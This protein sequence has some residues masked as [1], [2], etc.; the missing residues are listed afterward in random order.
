MRSARAQ[1]KT[2]YENRLLYEY[3]DDV[4]H[5]VATLKTCSVNIG[6]PAAL[7]ATRLPSV[8]GYIATRRLFSTRAPSLPTLEA[9]E[10]FHL[11][12]V[13]KNAELQARRLP[14]LI[15]TL[16]EKDNTSEYQKSYIADLQSSLE[17]LN[18]RSV[19]LP[20]DRC[21]TR[22]GIL[23]YRTYCEAHIFQVYSLLITSLC[24]S[25]HISST[26]GMSHWP[27]LSPILLL[28]QLSHSCWS[29]LS[30]SW[31]TAIV[32]YGIALTTLQRAERLAELVCESNSD[33]LVHELQN[34]G[35][36]NWSPYEHP[37]WL[38][39]EVESGIMIRHIQ[40]DIAKR[41][42]EPDCS[43][44][45][46][47]QL[48]MGE[49]KSSVI[50]PMVAAAL[51]DGSRLVRVIIAKPQSKQMAQMLIAKLG[52]L[53][54]HRIY[55]L[56][57]SRD[58][59]LDE[60]AVNVV[61]GMLRECMANR[62]ILLVQPEHIF[63][64]KLMGPECYIS[65]NEKIG[66]K[67]VQIEDFFDERSRDIVDESDENFSVRFELIYTMGVQNPIE[68]SPDRWYFAQQVFDILRR[69][70]P[71]IA[72]QSPGSLEIH[73]AH[74]GGLPRIR[75]L[76]TD[77]GV[78]L[79]NRI[80]KEICEGG[81][82]KLQIARQPA[83]VRRAVYVYIT[84]FELDTEEI[85]A[86][87]GEGFWTDA[88]KGPL[89]LLRGIL[90]GGVLVFTLSQKRWRVNYGLASRTP[91][92][93]LAVPYRAKDS[94]SLRSEFSHPDVVILLTSLCYYYQGLDDE[95]LFTAF[96]HLV[97]S[98]QADIE[99]QSWVHDALDL[100]TAFRQL[101]GVNL[102]DRAQ[103]A[104]DIFPAL[105]HGKSTVDYFLSHVVF[106]KE[107]RDFTHK[108]SA[109]GWDIGKQKTQLVTGFSGT[110]DSKY[111]LPL[112]VGQ[113]DL[114]GQKHTNA[115]VLENILQDGN[116]VE[117]L[118]NF[119]TE[120]AEVTSL[121]ASITQLKPEVQVILDVGAQILELSNVEVAASWLRLS[122]SSKEAVVF[123]N[124]KDEI[125]VMDREG[126]IDL[127]Y[128]SSYASRLDSCL[129]F[130]DESH[131]RG[132]DLKLPVH[133]RAAVTLGAG[134]TKDRLIQACMRMRRLGSGQTVVFCVPP[135]IQAKI[136]STGHVCEPILVSD[137]LLWS[138]GETHR[139]MQRS[140]PIWAVQGQRFTHQQILWQQIMKDGRTILN[141]GHAER[142]LE[143]ESQTLEQRYRPE[144]SS[145]SS[146]LLNLE[147]EDTSSKLIVD[148]C[149][150]FGH[151]Q[152]SSSVLHEEQERELA[153]EIEQERQVQK[154]PPATPATHCLHPDVKRFA[155]AK[156]VEGF[157]EAYMTAFQS[158]S[159][160]SMANTIDL[161]KLATEQR[162][163]VSADF[164]TTVRQD[165]ISSVYDAFQRHV[166]WVLTRSTPDGRNI[167]SVMVISPYEANLLYPYMDDSP[168]TLHIY[169]PR[170]NLG[171][172]SLDHLLL[173]TVSGSKLSPNVPRALLAQLSLFSGQLY[174]SSYTD[175]LEIC[176]F[177]GVSAQKLTEE[178]EREGWQLD[179]DGFI[180]NNG[181]GQPGGRTGMEDSPVSFFKTFL[182]KIRRNGDGIHKTHMG[183]LLDGRL[184][185]D[186]EW[187]V[188]DS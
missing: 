2:W 171:Y 12:E 53:A 41:M 145:Q 72:E 183:N 80:A 57:F 150:Q 40:A 70:A 188:K 8:C 48:N 15:Q 105:R 170:S 126:R 174:I 159:H 55:Y 118:S 185:S 4:V 45:A 11:K 156:S 151:L 130:L 86:V 106:P 135:E 119:A 58:L 59:L 17:A 76:R 28:Q 23:Q 66:Q 79:V 132:I 10:E 172:A 182:S 100:P 160:L 61:D 102:K 165:G 131:T 50:A 140:M 124:D 97:D 176:Q 98:D 24:H 168:H 162:L 167:D 187:Q 42:Q 73:A 19:G 116:S 36:T 90:A 7:S 62:G 88:T 166:S 38:L 142:F 18:S 46:V 175:Y 169:K 154:P 71:A 44:N 85:D 30:D 121:L 6:D 95:D 92:T 64:L 177:L 21:V 146:P 122:G 32:E 179:A 51:A 22:E 120:S 141:R 91:S 82:G 104:A 81:L 123:V 26:C 164:A 152:F 99:Y 29:Y 56:P 13:V 108:L 128:M 34:I 33:D 139:E 93:R 69:I 133:H 180:L 52:G 25:K 20:V 75:V 181:R 134:I 127:L 114:Q 111:L 109:S 153:P 37:D 67:L 3:L 68:M 94:P 43:H 117:L 65:N 110:N 83:K 136:K 49:G 125:C 115:M 144:S 178:M 147:V 173:H 148:R 35:H 149:Q 161:S 77:K 47:M 1:F 129:V 107:M 16:R 54:D 84:K 5:E 39:M 9:G 63:S 143:L 157:S 163:M 27:R 78:T 186:V 87:E 112:D 137:V 74:A 138:I 14:F 31:R 155:L 184:L 60:N 113:L 101:Q 103:C 158:L 89:L 96:A